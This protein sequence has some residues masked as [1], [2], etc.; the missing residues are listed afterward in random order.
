M[1]ANQIKP[2]SRASRI[3]TVCG[4]VLVGWIALLFLGCHD[5]AVGQSIPHIT[6]LDAGGRLTW[7]NA[8]VPGVCTVEVATA[9][10]GGWVTMQNVYSL[11]ST[12]QVALAMDATN[13]FI[14]LRAVDIQPTA[15]GFTN[16]I[17]AYG[18]L[19]TLRDAVEFGN[20]VRINSG[21]HEQLSVNG[22]SILAVSN[23]LARCRSV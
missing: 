3:R 13:K 2:P 21:S 19:E 18:V 12:G 20:L 17:Q 11:T 5:L 8:P 6:G 22:K 23:R 1:T 4:G 16:F 9:A 7:T 10:N 15:Q 14:R